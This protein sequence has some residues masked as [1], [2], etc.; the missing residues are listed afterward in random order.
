MAMV[1]KVHKV[2]H[3]P[4]NVH[5]DYKGCYFFPSEHQAYKTYYP[6]L[7]DGITLPAMRIEPTKPT[8][9]TIKAHQ[10]YKVFQNL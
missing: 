8:V 6:S 1:H 7:V 4:C 9:F 2:D 3:S 10:V 5:W